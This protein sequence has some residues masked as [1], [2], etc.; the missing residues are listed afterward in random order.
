MVYTLIRL[1]KAPYITADIVRITAYI[2]KTIPT[3]KLFRKAVKLSLAKVYVCISQ[4]GKAIFQKHIVASVNGKYYHPQPLTA[5]HR[6]TAKRSVGRTVTFSAS[7]IRQ[8][9]GYQSLSSHSL[10]NKL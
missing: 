5:E 10:R 8:T 3:L 7:E 2:F 6:A 4:L 1:F 9:A